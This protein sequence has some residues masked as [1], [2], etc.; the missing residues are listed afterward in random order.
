MVLARDDI[1]GGTCW[2]RHLRHLPCGGAAALVLLGSVTSAAL[3]CGNAADPGEPVGPAIQALSNAEARAEIVA[4]CPGPFHVHGQCA[5]CVAQA[6][7]LLENHGAIAAT[8]LEL[9]SFVGDDCVE[10]DACKPEVP[11]G[12]ELQRCVCSD[13]TIVDFCAEVECSSSQAQDAICVPAC[14]C[15]GG[16]FATAC[17]EQSAE[18]DS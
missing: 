13:G 14:S 5:S 7:H 12:P 4:M 17:V 9:S 18:C 6:S 11:L 15:N 10:H 1:V 2:P 3:G 16:L 8:L